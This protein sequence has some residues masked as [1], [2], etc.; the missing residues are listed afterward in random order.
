[1]GYSVYSVRAFVRRLED[2]R[3]TEI[4]QASE[5]LY[6]CVNLTF[7]FRDALGDL[8]VLTYISLLA[9][10]APRGALALSRACFREMRLIKQ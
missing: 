2:L 1:M 5:L 8:E 10:E 3:D 7:I 6:L 9:Q 4:N